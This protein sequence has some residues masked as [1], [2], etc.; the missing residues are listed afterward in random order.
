MEIKAHIDDIRSRLEREQFRNETAVRQGIVDRLLISL[1]WPTFDTEIVFPEYPVNGG[2]VDYALCH[3]AEKPIVFIEVKRVGNIETAE[4]QL[5]E[6]AFHEG[7]PILILTDGQKW[8]FFHPSGSGDYT[9]RLVQ[10]LDLIAN[11][12]EVIAVCLNRYLNYESVQTGRAGQ[13]VAEDYQKVSQQREALRHLPKAWENLVSGVSEDSEFLIEVV[14]SEI[15][16][17]CGSSPAHEQIFDF[18]N[19]ILKNETQT[20][21]NDVPP[22]LPDPRPS[23]I[24]PT[25][26]SN[27]SLSRGEKYTSYFQTLIDEMR[28][29]HNFTN[30]RRPI[31]S[32]NYYL[33]NSGCSGVSYLAK[34]ARQE[35]VYIGLYIKKNKNL[36]DILKERESEINAKFDVPICWDR[37]DGLL[38]CVIGFSRAGDITADAN[39][40]ESIRAWHVENLLKFKEVFTSEIQRALE[41][42]KSSERALE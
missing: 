7:V 2:R 39:V 37:K 19:D 22:P 30:A 18:L 12:G 15:Q 17:L 29:Q 27:S 32:Q 16:R 1:G 36:F 13:A 31:K 23:S 42:L 41:K 10:E 33:F 6:Y 14:K 28:E 24:S 25:A 20:F 21:Q 11:D 8:R 35:Q 5:F 40:L 34:F 3:P 26:V 38:K 9:E 4:R